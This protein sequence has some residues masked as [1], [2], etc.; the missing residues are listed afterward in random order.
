MKNSL[1]RYIFRLRAPKGLDNTLIKEL[2]QLGIMSK[3]SN[4]KTFKKMG[5]TLPHE[6]TLMKQVSQ[7]DPMVKKIQGRKALEIRG[8]MDTLWKILFK[9]RIVEDV[10]VKLG[11]SFQARGEDELRKNL[12]TLAW[13][14]YLPIKKEYHKHANDIINSTG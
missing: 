10:Q 14:S 7:I 3:E 1:S 4:F 8:G 11:S 6:K 5:S 12:R 2:N 13:D 9:S